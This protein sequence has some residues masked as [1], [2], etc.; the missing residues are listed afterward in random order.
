MLLLLLACNGPATIDSSAPVPVVDHITISQRWLLVPELDA[1]GDPGQGVLVAQAYDAND[2]LLNVDLSW[3]MDTA[4]VA[5]DAGLFSAQGEIGSTYVRAVYGTVSSPETLVYVAKTNPA[6]LVADD[7]VGE[8]IPLDN[9]EDLIGAQ[10]SVSLDLDVEPGELLI[11][12]GEALPPARVVSAGDPSSG[13]PTVL[14]LV[15]LDDAFQELDIQAHSTE[16]VRFDGSQEVVPFISVSVGKPLVFA[17]MDCRF[18]TDDSTTLLSIVESELEVEH[19]LTPTFRLQVSGGSVTYAEL[20]LDGELKLTA[21][22]VASLSPNVKGSFV[23][24]AVDPLYGSFPLPPVLGGPFIRGYV[25]FYAGLSG[26]VETQNYSPEFGLRFTGEMAF[27]AGVIYDGESFQD[28]NTFTADFELEPVLTSPSD[29]D[30]VISSVWPVVSVGLGPGIPTTPKARY[31][32]MV[33]FNAGPKLSADLAAPEWQAQHLDELSTVGMDFAWTV[34]PPQNVTD[35]VNGWLKGRSWLLGRLG[36]NLTGL[37]TYSDSTPIW[38]MP[39]GKL[40]LDDV[41]ATDGSVSGELVLTGDTPDFVDEVSVAVFSVSDNDIAELDSSTAG[42]S[43]YSWSG[44]NSDSSANTY[45]AF[46][47]TGLFETPLG[48]AGLDLECGHIEMVVDSIVLPADAVDDGVDADQELFSYYELVT[49]LYTYYA[50]ERDYALSQYQYYN[51]V[52]QPSTAASYYTLWEYY[53]A[54]SGNLANESIGDATFYAAVRDADQALLRANGGVE[55]DD[56]EGVPGDFAQAWLETGIVP[57]G[58][59]PAWD[60]FPS[61]SASHSFL[62]APQLSGSYPFLAM[63]DWKMARTLDGG[64]LARLQSFLGIIAYAT[65]GQTIFRINDQVITGDSSSLPAMDAEMEMEL[66]TE[67]TLEMAFTASGY[68]AAQFPSLNETGTLSGTVLQV[69]F[70]LSDGGGC[71]AE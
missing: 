47:H 39:T 29:D 69:V 38:A 26:E 43:S 59:V 23:C 50:A 31:Y 13:D 63:F 68:D 20:L 42:G 65:D 11:G 4:L 30:R 62:F 57:A 21:A 32:A 54:V 16:Y 67:Y 51:S 9:G 34:G 35:S 3:D 22:M 1:N 37:L 24:G 12:T 15:A 8:L 5:V 33:E 66:E 28:P 7:L 56:F 19:N 61:G 48:L 10:F 17:G 45:I 27:T 58:E 70:H 2:T 46:A 40:S 14:E 41:P 53:N 18:T 60:A 44:N 71:P 6:K 64:V 49:A 25:P 36:G 55:S 52:G